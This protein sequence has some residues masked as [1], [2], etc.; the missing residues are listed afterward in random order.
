MNDRPRVL[1]GPALLRLLLVA[2]VAGAAG[3]GLTRLITPTPTPVVGEELA[4]LTREFELTADQAARIQ[5]LHAAYRPV[6]AQHCAAIERTRTTLA[7]AASSEDRTAAEA[8][9]ER[10]VATC[11]DSTEAH[12]EAVAAVMSPDQGRRYLE[13]IRPR[14]SAHQH[15]QPFGLQ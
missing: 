9:L 11:H 14:L 15:A 12:L 6:C 8:Q 2:L 1:A 4:W 13:M 7:H 10:L 3:F 5:S